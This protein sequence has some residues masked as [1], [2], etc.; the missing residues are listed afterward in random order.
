MSEDH[1]AGKGVAEDGPAEVPDGK[2]SGARKRPSTRRQLAKNEATRAALIE[3]AGRV[4]GQH[5]Y[6]GASIARITAEAGIAHGAFYLHFAS[7]QALFDVLL[8][9]IGNDMLDAISAAIRD[10]HSLEEI[11]RRGITA[12]FAYLAQR[13]EIDRVMNEA[14]VVAPEAFTR[15]M[16]QIQ[17]RYRRSLIRSR[18]AGE[19]R[20]FSDE[21]IEVV[22]ALLTGARSYLLRLFARSGG[23]DIHPLAE[24]HI[25]VYLDVFLNGLSARSPKN[26]NRD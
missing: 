11:E 14:E 6:A 15:F 18:K 4:V 22:A 17:E 16:Q 26:K 12:N 3:A 13:P 20:G 8:L 7:R 1:G 24:K 19:L 10:S 23:T 5:G 2:A 25:D 21:E 9:E